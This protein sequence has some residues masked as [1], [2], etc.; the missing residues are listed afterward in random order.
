[1]VESSRAYEINAELLQMQD[2][3]T[4][5]AVSAVGRLR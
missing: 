3:L 4:G 5:Q 2:T 1:M